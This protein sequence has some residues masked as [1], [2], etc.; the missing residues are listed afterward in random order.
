MS[1]DKTSLERNLVPKSYHFDGYNELKCPNSRDRPFFADNNIQMGDYFLTTRLVNP[2]TLS[3]QFSSVCSYGKI[4]FSPYTL[5]IEE[6]SAKLQKATQ[7]GCDFITFEIA[8][9]YEGSDIHCKNCTEKTSACKQLHRNRPDKVYA[10]VS[11]NPSDVKKALAAYYKITK[12]TNGG[13]TSM[14]P[15]KNMFGMNL[16]FGI[17]KDPNIASTLMG[18]AVKTT[19]DGSWVIFD[20]ATNTRKNIGGMKMGNFPIVLLPTNTLMSGDL[21]KLNGK[22][23]SVKSVNQTAG[24]ITVIDTAAGVVQ[25]IIPESSLILGTPI[26][27]KVMAMDATTLTDKSSNQNISGNLLAAMCMMQWSEGNQADF[28]LDNVNDSSFNGL[29]QYLPLILASGGNLGGMFGSNDGKMDLSQLFMLGAVT[30]DSGSGDPTQMLVLSQLLGG[31]NSLFGS[32]A[33]A[34]SAVPAVGDTVVCESCGV[35][36][37]AGTNFCSKCGSHTKSLQPTCRECG[38]VLSNDAVFCSNCGTKVKLTSC[39]ECGADLDEGA[40]FCSKCG[41]NVSAKPVAAPAPAEQP[42]TIT[43]EAK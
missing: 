20:K 27:T 1:Y 3:L 38:A 37:P 34:T 7:E 25:D 12:T 41:H 9:K 22:Y 2:N 29:G 8:T 10:A 39:P 23:M 18:V 40:K 28:S 36:Y 21:I 30:G 42:E 11:F 16:E 24:T 5:T 15:K 14:R 17:S 35:T 32:V 6:Y 43:V 33:P 19:Y 26:F 4:T 13:M 31:G